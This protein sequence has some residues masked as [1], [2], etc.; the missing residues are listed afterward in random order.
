MSF[1]WI[2][3]FF[4]LLC[5]CVL[6]FLCFSCWHY[7]NHGICVWECVSRPVCAL[8]LSLPHCFVVLC[9]EL[10]IF[11]SALVHT[12]IF[13]VFTQTHSHIW[14]T[15][16][17]FHMKPVVH[18]AHS[19]H[20]WGGNMSFHINPVVLHCTATYLLWDNHY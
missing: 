20:I 15:N 1:L 11:S 4:R 17:R 3:F 13:F 10:K 19:Q 8:L 16:K 12:F 7:G 6:E 9:V 18:I 2:I 14:E 5:V